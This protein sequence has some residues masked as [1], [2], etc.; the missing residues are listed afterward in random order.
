MSGLQLTQLA[1]GY[2][3]PIV[4]DIDLTIAPGEIVAVLGPSGSG[5]STLLGTIVGT[6]PALGDA[7]LRTEPAPLTPREESIETGA[8][9][10]E[11]AELLN[12]F[13]APDGLLA[14]LRALGASDDLLERLGVVAPR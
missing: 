2:R 14:G 11:R 3:E 12:A 9:V 6:V 5:K 7:T 10:R 4:A 13:E 1:I 8:R